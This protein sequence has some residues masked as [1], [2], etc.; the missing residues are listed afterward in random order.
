MKGISVIICCY[1]SGNKLIPTLTHLAKQ[2]I[3][4]DNNA[5][6]IIVDNNCTDNTV[7]IAFET[8]ANL[9]RPFPLSVTVQ[10]LPGL[11]Y[12]RQ[13][14]ASVARY[15]Y[16]VMCDDDNWLCE[17]YLSGIYKLFETMP[18]VA[19]MG[20]VGEAVS[21]IR[22]PQWFYDM[23]GF[24]Y[25]VGNE[26]RK[27]GYVDSVYGAGMAF[28]KS[29]FL[30]QT[31][32]NYSFILTDRKG[33]ILSSGG[34][35]EISMLV[36]DAGYKI[37]L[38]TSLTFKHFLAGERLQWN[39]YLNLRK[40]FG[41]AN[42]LL[43]LYKERITNN[44][45]PVKKNKIRQFLTLIKFVANHLNFLLFPGSAKNET[46]AGF[47]QEMSKRVTL[48]TGNKITGSHTVSQRHVAKNAFI[49]AD[50]N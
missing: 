40:S 14:G 34:D 38:D 12:A 10:P 44:N 13:K 27:T 42:A 8:W 41:K 32:N 23:K 37:Y 33:K 29:V 20:G 24:G 3:S 15:E 31:E 35:T 21:D 25:A 39:Y 47:M 1:N 17:D 18:E 11:N 7:E 19:M 5:E 28:R 30:S 9:N 49:H 26:G 4:D 6:I 43:Q 16:I 22:L 45:Q 46:C 2:K 50:T 36:K 48:F